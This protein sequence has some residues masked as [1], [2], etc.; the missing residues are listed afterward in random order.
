MITGLLGLKF[1]KKKKWI[2]GA[3]VWIWRWK[4]RRALWVEQWGHMNYMYIIKPLRGASSTHI[5]ET[6]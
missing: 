5:L 2:V 1:Q 3:R 6:K 4:W